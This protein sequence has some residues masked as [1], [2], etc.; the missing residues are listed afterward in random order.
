MQCYNCQLELALTKTPARAET[1]PKCA[2]YLHCC[3]NCRFYDVN[4]HN[5]CREPQAEWVKDKEMANFCDFFEAATKTASKES[6]RKEEAR[7]KLDD[8]FKR[9]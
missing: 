9:K 7:K 2:S 5:Q 8:L 4:A 3:L 6:A 1:C